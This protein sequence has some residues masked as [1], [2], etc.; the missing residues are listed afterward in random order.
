[1]AERNLS[2]G[3]LSTKPATWQGECLAVGIF[4][5]AGVQPALLGVD[6]GLATAVDTLRQ[7]GWGR[8]R[9]G[10]FQFVPMPVTGFKAGRILLVGLGKKEKLSAEALRGIGGQLVSRC[11]QAG[12]KSVCLLLTLEALG[13]VNHEG[14]V[15]ALAEGALLGSY[16]FSRFK[17]QIKEEDKPS[18]ERLFL[19]VPRAGAKAQEARLERTRKI[20]DG[21]VL[22]RDLGNLPPCDLTPES[23]AKE[24]E[25]LGKRHNV[26][27]TIHDE[28]ALRRQGMNGILAV[29]QGSAHPPRLIVL[30]YRKGGETPPLAV[31]GKAVTFDSGG[32]SIKPSD[33][34]DEMKFDMCGGA[35]VLGLFEAVAALDLPVNLIGLVP[36]AENMPSGTAQRPGDIIKMASG[37]FV[38]VINTDAEGRLILADALHHASSFKPGA[39][40]D[41]ATLTGA[42]VV[43]LGTHAA[44]LMG[45]DPA[46]LEALKKAGESSGERLWPMPLFDEY[47]EQIK[48]GV[49]DIKNAG[50]REGGAITAGCF[51]SRFVGEGIPWAHLDIAGTAWDTVGTRGHVPK[52]A[53]GFGVRLLVRH[54][55]NGLSA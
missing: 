18:L 40:V 28:K 8:G 51:L 16:R 44:G 25:A 33:K 55:L 20:I 22:S 3:I 45:T 26:K 53:V 27:V 7:G 47:Q 29:G 31:V 35:A 50:N 48:S 43:A 38:E 54:L 34:M 15:E 5:D 9:T 2:I 1:M 23:L 30:E 42:I 39:I 24:A 11:D 12:L 41:L 10:E 13:G 49:A 21:V 46:L 52:G 37:L 14:V 19:A 17:S 32:I 36:A 6:S 4:E